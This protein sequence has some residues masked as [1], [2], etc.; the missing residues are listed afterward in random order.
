MEAVVGGWW[1]VAKVSHPVLHSFIIDCR[2][3]SSP[4]PVSSNFL[5]P[6]LPLYVVPC[7]ATARHMIAKTI[8]Q[9]TVQGGRRRG[10]QRKRWEDNIR[11]WIG[12]EWNS[13]LRKAENRE[14]WRTL[15]VKS[16]MVSVRLPD[17]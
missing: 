12:L 8:L 10:R 11:E 7:F 15:A 13:I 6:L 2:K 3:Y 14:E 5:G 17:R 4:T 9:G 16:A 1:V